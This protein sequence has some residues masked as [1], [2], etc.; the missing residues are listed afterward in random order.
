MFDRREVGVDG[1]EEWF[2]SADADA[3]VICCKQHD[4]GP[5]GHADKRLRASGD[6]ADCAD[7]SQGRWE[8]VECR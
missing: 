8:H 1:W 2:A 7:V 4:R 5:I 3:I 6:C